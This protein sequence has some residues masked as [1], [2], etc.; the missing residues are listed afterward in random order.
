MDEVT[1]PLDHERIGKKDIT[2]RRMMNAKGWGR[3]KCER[4]IAKAVAQKKLVAVKV[5]NETNQETTA[6]RKPVD[7]A[8]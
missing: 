3:D 6:Y 8:A 1:A 5:L 2:V 7:I 4:A